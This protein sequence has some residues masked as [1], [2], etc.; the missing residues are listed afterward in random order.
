MGVQFC[1]SV[2]IG[3]DKTEN[4]KTIGE[5]K[6]E[7]QAII[8]ATGCPNHAKLNVKGENLP[9][10]FHGIPFLQ[11]VRAGK[12][13]RLGKKVVVIGGGNV[14]VDAAQTALRLG[15]QTVSMVCLESENE[16]PAM[17]E[18]LA[19]AKSEGIELKYSWGSPNFFSID[20]QLDSVEFMRCTS[21]FDAHGNFSPDFDSCELKSIEADSVIIAIGQKTDASFLE[22]LGLAADIISQIDPITLQT[23]DE[24]IFMAGDVMTGPSSVIEAMAKGRNA[25]ESAHR[26]IKGE[27]L[28]YGRAYEGPIET[29]FDID[30][31]RGNEL[32]RHNVSEHQC[33]GKSDFKELVNSYDTV[34]AQ[35]EAGRCYSCGDPFGK[36][37][38]C[39]FCLPCEVECPNDA[40]YVEIPYLMR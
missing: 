2:A 36:F 39:W 29:D 37:R 5:L 30:T 3:S 27:H 32:K 40:L 4:S 22:T 9:G 34:T 10:V 19:M 28:K 18:D 16:I 38:T 25:A 31:S 35:K 20:G 23:P 12:L 11:D 13:L 1:C 24:M 26:F 14:A 6:K 17:E 33:Q 15:A 8:L 21:V 7:F